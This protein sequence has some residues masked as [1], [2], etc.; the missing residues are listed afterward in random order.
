M[1]N[2]GYPTP[3]KTW[4]DSVMQKGH[5]Y[6][7]DH[8]GHM[9]GLQHLKVCLIYTSGIVFDQLSENTGWSGLEAEGTHLFEYMRTQEVR[10]VHVQVT[11]MLKDNLIQ[12]RT[13][14]S[15]KKLNE[16][17]IDWFGIV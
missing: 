8:N 11:D 17:A 4:L 1:C 12:F 13:K 15:H 3:V 7:L 14:V 5:A 6:D 10:V 2:F 9:P 16:L